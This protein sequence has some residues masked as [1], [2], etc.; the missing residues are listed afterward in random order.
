MIW[1]LSF[2]DRDEFL[3]ACVVEAEGGPL[4][5]HRTSVRQ[6][7]NPLRGGVVIQRLPKL[8]GKVPPRWFGVLLSRE[9]CN[10]FGEAFGLERET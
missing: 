9:D 5:A 1:W 8:I 10:A 4:E 7:C 3:G 6:G 2:V